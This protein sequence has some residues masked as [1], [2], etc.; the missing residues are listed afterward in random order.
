MSDTRPT[1]LVT[2]A[3]GFLGANLGAFLDGRVRRIGTARDGVAASPLFD[4][5]IP[6]DLVRPDGL[7]AAIE[8]RRPDVV[9]HAAAMASHERC[10]ADP[11]MAER[12]NAY[13]VGVL[14][15][16]AER[17]GARFVLIST[18]AVFDGDR[19]A[20]SEADAPNPGSVYGHTK[21]RGEVLAARA[22]DAL[23][24]R[25]NFFGWSP[26]GTRSILEFF[27]N[28]LSAGNRVRGFTDFTT[29]SAYAQV[30]AR[31]IWQL[32]ESDASGLF[33]ATSPDALTKYEFGVAVASTFGLDAAL[34]EPASADVQP[35]RGRDISLDVSKVEGLLAAP[36]PTQREGLSQAL[37]DS[38]ALR[39]T[40]AGA[41]GA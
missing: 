6:A 1:W 12:I 26:S 2:G 14:A 38:T 31:T 24:V 11:A 22:T 13:A 32:T 17:A 37:A 40:I 41:P 33:H 35:P 5:W 19:G 28:Q 27:V 4:D 34:I 21:L 30:L 25:T 8:E 3:T 39:H 7:S 10:E 9:V 20:Y 36:M 23:V 29:T 18:D 16:A 15:H